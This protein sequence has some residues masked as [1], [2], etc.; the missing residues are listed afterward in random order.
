MRKRVSR[1]VAVAS[2]EDWRER[3]MREIFQQN[4]K[5][6]SYL[7]E[8]DADLLSILWDVFVYCN[9]G[10][11]YRG[12]ED[13]LR[14]TIDT[15]DRLADQFSRVAALLDETAP[16]VAQATIS[17]ALNDMPGGVP[18]V[19][20]LKRRFRGASQQIAICARRYG[21]LL[22][23]EPGL[24]SLQLVGA[25][26]HLQTAASLKR[27]LDRSNDLLALLVDCGYRAHGVAE[28]EQVTS[29]AINK[30]INHVRTHYPNQFKRV[31]LQ[32]MDVAVK[33]ADTPPPVRLTDWFRLTLPPPR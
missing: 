30:K 24:K 15:M 7:R 11:R 2:W 25:L 14:N 3:V 13:W 16:T 29:N 17:G 6:G 32:A 12:T 22:K 5:E 33:Y 20:L 19:I 9:P 26:A 28:R 4:P 8:I 23:R 18:N 21:S 10:R 1:E 31:S 27:K